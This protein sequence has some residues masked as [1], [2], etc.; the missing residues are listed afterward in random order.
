MNMHAVKQEAPVSAHPSEALAQLAAHAAQHRLN[1][2]PYGGEVSPKEAYA[3][4]E[5]QPALLVDVRTVPEWQFVGTPDV[6]A[7]QSRLLTLSWKHY[8]TFAQNEQ[9]AQQLAAQQGVSTDTPLFFICRSGGRSLD[10]AIAMAQ[11]GY[12]YSFNVSGGFEGDADTKAH[13]GIVSGW[14]A[15]AL[16]WGQG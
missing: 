16:P 2:L 10:A 3:F 1:D 13:R 9:F 8:P 15:D 11:L 14:K 5:V 7:T 6:S 4:M 12:R